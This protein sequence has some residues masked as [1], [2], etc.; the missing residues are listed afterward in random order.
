[1]NYVYLGQAF[2]PVT[3]RPQP[4]DEVL[5]RHFDLPVACL[6]VDLNHNGGIRRYGAGLSCYF[7]EHFQDPDE[8]LPLVAA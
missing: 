7:R 3:M 1:M 8:V 4:C 5:L 2:Q 6:I